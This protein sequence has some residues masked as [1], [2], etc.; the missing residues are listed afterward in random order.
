M[1]DGASNGV[2]QL[3]F[4]KDNGEKIKLQF[5]NYHIKYSF[6]KYSLFI[7]YKLAVVDP[8]ATV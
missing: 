8:F 7:L 1:T 3:E 4:D 2:I 6:D 5:S